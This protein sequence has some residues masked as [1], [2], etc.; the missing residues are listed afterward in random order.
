MLDAVER[1][2]AAITPAIAAPRSCAELARPEPPGP[3][4]PDR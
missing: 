2:E 3:R 1:G 4:D